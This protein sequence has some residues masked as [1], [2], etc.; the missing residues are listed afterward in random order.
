MDNITLDPGSRSKFNVFGST[1]YCCQGFTGKLIL[2]IPV[3][4]ESTCL[5]RSG[6]TQ[7]S[8]KIRSQQGIVPRKN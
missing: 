7:K 8:P 1:T 3:C 6:F 5:E 2:Q 4:F